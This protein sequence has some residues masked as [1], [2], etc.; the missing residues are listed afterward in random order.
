MTKEQLNTFLAGFKLS[1][2]G[3]VTDVG[4]ADIKRKM[5]AV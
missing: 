4:S 5:L 2:T 3:N 1:S